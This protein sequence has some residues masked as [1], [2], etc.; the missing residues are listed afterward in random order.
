VESHL[1]SGDLAREHTSDGSQRDG[2]QI[3]YGWR[4]SCIM[5]AWML[6]LRGVF[7]GLRSTSWLVD[8]ASAVD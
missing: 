8:P 7:G 5:S 1:P 2:N 6:E 4:R 3:A